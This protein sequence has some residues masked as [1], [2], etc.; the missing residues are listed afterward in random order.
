[1]GVLQKAQLSAPV[2]AGV[3]GEGEKKTPP[4][5]CDER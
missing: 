3:K 5:A 1:M 4:V 2:L